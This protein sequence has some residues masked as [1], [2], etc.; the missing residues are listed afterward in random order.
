MLEYTV[1]IVAKG[2][3]MQLNAIPGASQYYALPFYIIEQRF[4]LKRRFTLLDNNNKKP[5]Q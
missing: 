3:E 5:T 1:F 2:A 4:E